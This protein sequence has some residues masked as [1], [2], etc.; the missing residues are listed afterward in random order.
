M[1]KDRR[2]RCRSIVRIDSYGTFDNETTIKAPEEIFSVKI[3]ITASDFISSARSHTGFVRFAYLTVSFQTHVDWTNVGNQFYAAE[4][5]VNPHG[6]NWIH[7]SVQ[8]SFIEGNR[9]RILCLHGFSGTPYELKPLSTRLGKLDYTVSTPVLIGHGKTTQ[10][11]AD[12]RWPDWLMSAKDAFDELS[13]GK[14]PVTVIGFSMGGL[15][16]LKL[17]HERGALVRGTAVLAPAYR[18][19]PLDELQLRVLRKIGVLP[20]LP[21]FKRN[22]PDISKA[23]VRHSMQAIVTSH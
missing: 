14:Y 11:L 17:A 16:A 8:P 22:G 20:W 9:G 4:A 15:L 7:P 2:C 12:S 6:M 21:A 5:Y 1:G 3:L 19:N 23:D 10:Q 13:E 18:I